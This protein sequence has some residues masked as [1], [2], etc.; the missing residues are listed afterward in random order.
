MQPEDVLESIVVAVPFLLLA[1]LFYGLAA[2]KKHKGKSFH[3]QA[4]QLIENGN[5][6]EAREVLLR[7]LW[8][9]NEEP[10]LER[11]ILADLREL[12]T[13]VG[14]ELE[15]DD[16]DLLISQYE[17]LSRKGSHKAWSDLK[18]VQALKSE[19]I[20]RLPKVA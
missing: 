6:T 15:T 10:H 13:R 20:D 1:A 12:Y 2:R 5:D 16:Y 3:S 14:I 7:A 18:Q 17:S 4:K 11:N 8:S 19:L 9:A